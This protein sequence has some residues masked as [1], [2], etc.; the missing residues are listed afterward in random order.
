MYDC[1]LHIMYDYILLCI[2]FHVSYYMIV[3]FMLG[4]CRRT[5]C[6]ASPASPR[7]HTETPIKYYSTTIVLPLLLLLLLLLLQLLLYHY[8]TILLYYYYY[9]TICIVLPFIHEVRRR[10]ARAVALGAAGGREVGG[11]GVVVL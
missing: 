1:V 4:P 11:D 8:V 9:S 2:I 3:Y 5:S 6:A 7:G 10:A